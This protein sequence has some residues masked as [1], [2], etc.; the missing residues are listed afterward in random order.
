MVARDVEELTGRTRHTTPE[1]VDE[2]G[3]RCPVL[4]CRDGV[5]IGRTRELGAAI[6]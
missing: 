2:G 1:P 6:G 3:A 5:I 4:K